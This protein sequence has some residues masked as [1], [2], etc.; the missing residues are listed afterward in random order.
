MTDLSPDKKAEIKA[1][2]ISSRV[3]EHV[4]HYTAEQ[5]PKYRTYSLQTFI[6]IILMLIMFGIG[7]ILWMIAE[8]LS[9]AKATAA[10]ETVG[11]LMY[12][13]NFGVSFI[14][15][16]FGGFLVLLPIMSYLQLFSKKWRTASFAYGMGDW[17][18]GFFMFKKPD[19]ELAPDDYIRSFFTR[20]ARVSMKWSA[21]TLAIATLVGVK[22]I[23]AYE[24]YG[25]TQIGQAKL[26]SVSGLNM[27]E[28]DDIDYVELG[29]NHITG[30]NASDDIIYRIKM[31]NGD[32][33]YMENAKPVR[34]SWL[35]N[36]AAIDAALEKDGV[37]FKRW[38]WLKREP[39]HPVC[40][41]AQ[42]QKHSAEDYKKILNLLRVSELQE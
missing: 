20:M 1:R 13:T 25:E 17:N 11:A 3:P 34:G 15:A 38:S 21:A 19:P 23:Q 41:R 2:L 39:L 7:F 33:L 9:E 5:S 4:A 6:M 14:I 37:T 28:T 18:S 42:N 12:K 31:K 27:R 22:D 24:V 8:S 35:D 16:L 26:L 36:A 40:L 10:V 29:C 32:T 30:K